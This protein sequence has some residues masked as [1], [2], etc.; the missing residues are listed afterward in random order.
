MLETYSSHPCL[1]DGGQEV[2]TI[3]LPLLQGFQIKRSGIPFQSRVVFRLIP[4]SVIQV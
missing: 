2:S 4:L 1:D 3:R